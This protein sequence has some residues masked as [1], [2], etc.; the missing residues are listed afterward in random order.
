MSDSSSAVTPVQ[1]QVASTSMRFAAPSTP[2][3]CPPRM[4][5]SRGSATILTQI[6]PAPG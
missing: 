5:P 2:T 3:I 6:G 1:T 4:R